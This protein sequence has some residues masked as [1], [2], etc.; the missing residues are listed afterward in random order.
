MPRPPLDKAEIAA[1]RA[2]AAEMADAGRK[3]TLAHFR[4]PGLDAE[5]KEA[6]RF[7]PVTIADRETEAALRAVLARHR[8]MDA[9]LGEEMAATPGQSGLT[10]VIDPIDGTRSYL[11]GTPTWGILIA[12]CDESGPIYGLIDQPFIGER[13]EG[14]LGS[15]TTTGPLGNR[16]LRSRPPCPLS[17]AILFSTFPEVGTPTEGRAF[18]TLASRVKLVRYGLDCY[19]YALVAAGHIDLVVEAGLQPYDVCA[20]IALITAAGGVVTDWQGGPAHHGGRILAAANP[21]IHA[22]AL[23][24][25]QT[26]PPG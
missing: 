15:A 7:D 11:A 12:L 6:A 22:E 5:T 17:E 21:E 25:L 19:A 14:G 4:S 2:V 10:W 20:P 23:K 18:H 8:P 16:A 26:A 3:T 13:F 1:I 9:I 24:I